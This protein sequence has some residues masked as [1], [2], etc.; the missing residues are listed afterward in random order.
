LRLHGFPF[1]YWLIGVFVTSTAAAMGLALSAAVR[2]PVSALW[3]INFLVIPQLLFAGSITRLTG[4]TWF[5]SWLTTTRYALEALVNIDLYERGHLAGCQ[6]ERYMVNLP[7][8]MP[9]LSFPLVY[10]W[11]G[12]GWIGVGCL[13]LT[14][15]LLKMKDKR[16]G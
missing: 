1:W 6:I 12:T 13:F 3:G 9:D 4:F 10:A 7:G 8:F 15:F 2:N 5:V 16:V 14:M 11:L